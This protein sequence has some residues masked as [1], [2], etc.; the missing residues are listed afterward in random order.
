M[1]VMVPVQKYGSVG[2]RKEALPSILQQPNKKKT[3][4]FDKKH[5]TYSTET[6]WDIDYELKNYK[7][8]ATSRKP[9][10]QY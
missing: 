8:E 7:L 9:N 5:T 1:W 2:F 10:N 3:I 6:F 4:N